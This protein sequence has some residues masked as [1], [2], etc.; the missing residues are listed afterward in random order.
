MANAARYNEANKA[1]YRRCA[2]YWLRLVAAKLA[3]PKGTYDI[4]FNPGGIACGGDATLH[5][6]S[7]YLTLNEMGGYFRRCKGRKDYTGERN[8]WFNGYGESLSNETLLLA[9]SAQCLTP[10]PI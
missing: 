6:D 7:F 2:L 1:T 10:K 4:R 8:I 3:L 5:H 9:I